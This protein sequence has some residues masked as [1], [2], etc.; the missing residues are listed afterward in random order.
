MWLWNCHAGC[1][2]GTI[3]D[4]AMLAF[5]VKGAAEAC[6]EIEKR[7]GITFGRDEA[8]VEPRIDVD[9]A[10]R[11][12]KAANERL[13]SDFEVQDKYLSGKRG[14]TDLQIVER[15]RLGWVE[16]VAFRGW[17]SWR[18]TG[19]VIPITDAKGTL[20][21][22]RLH[23]EGRRLRDMP[24]CLWAPFGTYPAKK[25]KHGT[26][27]LWPPPEE[28]TGTDRLYL[29]PGELKGLCAIG[30]GVAAT[31]VTS[32][33]SAKFP[34]RFAERIKACK[35]CEVFVV[36]DAD[37]AG[38]KWRDAAL[39]ALQKVGVTC[40]S[41][42]YG[43]HSLEE[44]AALPVPHDPAP[45]LDALQ[46]QWDAALNPVKPPP[47]EDERFAQCQDPRLQ[48]VLIEYNTILPKANQ[49]DVDAC[50]LIGNITGQILALGYE[51]TEEEIRDGFEVLLK[52]GAPCKFAKD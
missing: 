30:A 24:K 7:L 25:P 39:K 15:Y 47:T 32:G 5:N 21:A 11:L 48:T 35:P 17:H 20:R 18:F 9:R 19:W 28:W 40:G 34:S 49:G 6:R 27:T 43:Q 10:E 51:P 2:A 42:H 29:H 3:I 36:Y 12:V 23:S 37:D 50:G 14:I 45:E 8:Y 44:V 31:S 1:G 52:G 4:A 16:K 46:A 41:F 26:I 13:L 33:E 22:V 38:I